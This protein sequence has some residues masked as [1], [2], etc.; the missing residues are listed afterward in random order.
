MWAG[1]GAFGGGTGPFG[2]GMGLLGGG[3]TPFGRD[4][5]RCTERAPSV[6]WMAGIGGV[7]VHRGGNNKHS[8][9]SF[10]GG[11]YGR[12]VMQGYHWAE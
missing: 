12:K 9:P 10:G 4:G 3:T 2:G 7:G 1:G 5:F 6:T 11:L 8:S